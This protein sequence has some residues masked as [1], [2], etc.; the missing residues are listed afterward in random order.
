MHAEDVI[1]L[2]RVWD[3]RP[4]DKGAANALVAAVVEYAAPV[5]HNEIYRHVFTQR[6][7]G[8]SLSAAFYTWNP[9]T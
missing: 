3:S 8:L 9:P 2:W 7:A 5:N 4:G 6:R 1:A